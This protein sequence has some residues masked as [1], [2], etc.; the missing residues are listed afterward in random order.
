MEPQEIARPTL[1]REEPQPVR[2]A[3]SK[4]RVITVSDH[5]PKPSGKLFVRAWKCQA[6]MS[7]PW[8]VLDGMTI[9]LETMRI[10]PFRR[11]RRLF[12]P[13]E[14]CFSAM[15][16]MKGCCLAPEILAPGTALLPLPPFTPCKACVAGQASPVLMV[17]CPF[18]SGKLPCST[19]YL[20]GCWP[21]W[22]GLHAF[23]FPSRCY[24]SWPSFP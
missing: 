20:R 13:R 11:T 9:L 7:P 8:H 12:R 22:E 2:I 10:Q 4:P 3:A 16:R 18:S 1:P 14:R 15:R 6:A 21:S 5:H 17:S 19:A 24:D 23:A